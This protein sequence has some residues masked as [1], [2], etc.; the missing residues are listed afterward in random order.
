[1]EEWL[2]AIPEFELTDP[3]AVTFATG[4]TWGPRSVPITYPVA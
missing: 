3:E 2:K 4:H 1:V